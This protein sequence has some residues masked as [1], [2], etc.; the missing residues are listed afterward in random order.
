MI[1]DMF[2]Y[3]YRVACCDAAMSNW[4]FIASANNIRNKLT[5]YELNIINRFNSIE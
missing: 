2:I 4:L 3:L 5:H 1:F